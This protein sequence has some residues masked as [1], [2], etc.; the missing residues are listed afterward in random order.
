MKGI[1]LTIAVIA[2]LAVLE[3]HVEDDLFEFAHNV[4]GIDFGILDVLLDI[5][6]LVGQVPVE[7]AITFRRVSCARLVARTLPCS[8]RARE[9]L[10]PGTAVPSIVQLIAESSGVHKSVLLILAI[11]ST[12]SWAIVLYKLW[13]FRRSAR[14]STSF[15]DV[16]RRSSKFSEVQ[17]VCRSLEESPLVGLFQAGYT[18]LTAQLHQTRGNCR[19]LSAPDP[20]RGTQRL[21][22][23]SGVSPRSIAP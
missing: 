19:G 5:L 7:V 21:V 15:L 11:F 12:V 9:S 10:D 22:L 18:E 1:V 16:F 2:N 8:C 14:Q 4:G 13:M 23:P 6:F 20:V 17:A 3:H